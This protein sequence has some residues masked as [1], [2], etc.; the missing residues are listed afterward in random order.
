M[1]H[2][3]SV[4]TD[5][6]MS[7]PGEAMDRDDGG[8]EEDLIFPEEAGL[9]TV[10]EGASPQSLGGKRSQNFGRERFWAKVIQV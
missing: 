9:S 8:A 10:S 1:S 3:S 6:T 7:D 2:Q 4:M 5:D